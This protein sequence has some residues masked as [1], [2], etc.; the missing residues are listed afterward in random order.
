MDSIVY[1][2]DKEIFSPDKVKWY[3]FFIYH[4]TTN[5]I[6]EDMAYINGKSSLLRQNSNNFKKQVITSDLSKAE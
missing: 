5:K 1:S 2:A 6:V 3:F 4:I